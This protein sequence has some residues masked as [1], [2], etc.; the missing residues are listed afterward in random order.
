VSELGQVID[1]AAQLQ[2]QLD[3]MREELLFAYLCVLAL[4]VIVAAVAWKVRP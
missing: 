3:Q 4:T 1:H 2:E